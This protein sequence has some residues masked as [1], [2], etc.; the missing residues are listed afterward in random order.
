MTFLDELGPLKYLQGDWEGIVG[1]DI[2][3]DDAAETNRQPKRSPYRERMTF[4][5]TGQVDN[6]EQVL[7]GLR[8][9][10]TAWRLHAP[11]PFHEEVGYWMWDAS[12]GMVIRSFMPPRGMAILAGGTATATARTFE[13]TAELGSETYGICSTPFL[14][15]EF[16][17][18]K[19]EIAVDL[20]KD[21]TLHYSQ[22]TWMKLKDQESLFDHHDENT[23]HRIS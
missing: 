15:R 1:Q 21:D 13:L 4:A 14:W 18:V 10:T 9:T 11:D 5:P 19:Y 7:F 6:H 17:T 23:L 2:A 8:Y 12:S 16:R 3:P 22:H 20:S